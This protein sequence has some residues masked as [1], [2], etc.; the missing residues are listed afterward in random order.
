MPIIHDNRNMRPDLVEPPVANVDDIFAAADTQMEQQR[1]KQMFTPSRKKIQWKK[2]I[3]R[4]VIA[5]GLLSVLIIIISGILAANY[6]YN[7]MVEELQTQVLAEVTN[8]KSTLAAKE[9]SELTEEDLL[10]LAIFDIIS[11][12]DIVRMVDSAT[13]IEEIIYM[14][15]TQNV[16]INRYLTLEQQKELEEVLTQYAKDLEVRAQELEQQS[17]EA[18]ETISTEETL[19]PNIEN[20]NLEVDKTDETDASEIIN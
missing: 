12:E 15:R 17:L 6:S 5:T 9:E 16:D 2:R 4:T 8:I 10:M 7:L 14:I 1:R 11:E 20:N 13:S 19:S 3:K 18:T